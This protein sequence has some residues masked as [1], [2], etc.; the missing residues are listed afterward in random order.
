MPVN[1]RSLMFI[2]LA[3]VAV[4]VVFFSLNFIPGW[5]AQMGWPLIF[6][7]IAA[8]LLAPVVLLPGQREW[9]AA[10]FIPAAVQLALGV[11]FLYNTISGDWNAWAYAWLLILSGVGI[12]LILAGRFGKWDRAVAITGMWILVVSLMLFGLF[13]ALFGRPALKMAAPAILIAGGVLLLVQSMR[14][15]KST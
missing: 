14:R 2:G 1:N 3:L 13:G 15:A 12:G 10:L 7:L 4:G 5:T 8:L 9:T 11:I 6:F